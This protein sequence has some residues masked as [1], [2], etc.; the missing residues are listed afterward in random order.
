MAS[1]WTLV[2]DSPRAMA[3]AKDGG[4]EVF[5]WGLHEPGQAAALVAAGVSGLDVDDPPVFR[6]ALTVEG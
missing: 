3:A 4:A 6:E 5:G 1:F 2:L